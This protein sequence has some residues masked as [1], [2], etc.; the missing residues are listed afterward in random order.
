MV[1]HQNGDKRRGSGND[2]IDSGPC[3]VME[4][5]IGGKRRERDENEDGNNDACG[6]N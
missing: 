2:D 1:R 4:N 3:K 5:F 6:T